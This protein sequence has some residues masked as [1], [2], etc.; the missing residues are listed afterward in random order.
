[1][2]FRALFDFEAALAEY[3]GAPYVVL[4]DGC[5]HSLELCLKYD[6]VNYCQL[7][8]FTYISVSMTLHIAGVKFDYLEER[9][10]TW[11]GEYQLKGTRIWDS[12]RRL[13]RGMYKSGQ[14]Q[15]LSFGNTKPLQL[16]KVGCILLDDYQAYKQLSMLRSDGRDL[17]I[18]PWISQTSMSVGYHYAPSLESCEKGLRLL[19]TINKKP[20]FVSYPDC[21]LITINN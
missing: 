16:G 4:T 18:S 21:R 8:P 6:K 7:T 12:A 15:C 10:Q 11:I 5:T 14:M 19:K 13:E 9:E 20:E 3:T 1:M 2:S 17:H